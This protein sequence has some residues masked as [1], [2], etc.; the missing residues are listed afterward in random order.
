M[1]MPGSQG[2]AGKRVRCWDRVRNDVKV[3]Y[4]TG[5]RADGR[6]VNSP[7]NDDERLIEPVR[8]AQ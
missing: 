2:E 6:P 5:T 7:K 4:Q 3:A 8:L 1:S